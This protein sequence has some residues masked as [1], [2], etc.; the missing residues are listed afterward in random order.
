MT[1]VANPAGWTNGHVDVTITATDSGSGV[2]LINPTCTPTLC[3]VVEPFA[4][5]ANGSATMKLQA[6]ADGV[7]TISATATDNASNTS[8]AVTAT[9]SI[10]RTAPT[11]SASVGGDT[12][13]DGFYGAGETATITFSCSDVSASGVTASGVARCELLDGT[14]VAA[15]T[16]TGTATPYP[17]PGTQ[18][19][20]KSFTVRAT[21]NARTH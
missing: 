16:T 4:P 17:I 3:T 10:D 8:P 6:T 19:G 21:D 9:A 5:A 13:S 1:I 18:T 2:A 7:T 20:T 11:A 14:T 15:S 12:N